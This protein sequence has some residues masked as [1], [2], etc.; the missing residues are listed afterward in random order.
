MTFHKPIVLIVDPEYLEEI[1][2][3][4]NFVTRDPS[5]QIIW[6]PLLGEGSSI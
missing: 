2:T 1:F 3:N 6:G 4:K 5:K